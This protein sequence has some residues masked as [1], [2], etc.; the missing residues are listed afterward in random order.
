MSALGK[1]AHCTKPTSGVWCGVVQCGAECALIWSGHLSLSKLNKRVCQRMNKRSSNH[2]RIWDEGIH[3]CHRAQSTITRNQASTINYE[4]V[5]QNFEQ[6][7]I[8]EENTAPGNTRQTTVTAVTVERSYSR[9]TA[10]QQPTERAATAAVDGKQSREADTL[11][12]RQQNADTLDSRQQTTRY[13]PLPLA[14][15]ASRSS[16]SRL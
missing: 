3:T 11:G 13:V 6:Q 16:D 8:P 12:S 2:T 4:L 7:F 5:Q 15:M 10:G 1:T 9:H 14:E